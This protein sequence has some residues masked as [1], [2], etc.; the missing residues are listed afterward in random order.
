MTTIDIERNGRIGRLLA[1]NGNLIKGD[2]GDLMDEIEALKEIGQHLGIA[3]FY[4]SK[5]DVIERTKIV[6]TR[7]GVLIGNQHK[8]KEVEIRILHVNI[9]EGIVTE[10]RIA[11]E[12]TGKDR[13]AERWKDVFGANHMTV[14]HHDIAL[15][16]V[17]INAEL[18]VTIVL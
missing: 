16:G 7:L 5:F 13:V 9:F 4:I 8:F 12:S 11:A 2:V 18:K 3:H 1:G 6:V 15:V 17:L 14:S 10:I